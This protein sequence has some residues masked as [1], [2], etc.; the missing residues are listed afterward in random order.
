[1]ILNAEPLKLRDGFQHPEI[2]LHS[3]CLPSTQIY[4]L[5]CTV[6]RRIITSTFKTHNLC[7]MVQVKEPILQFSTRSDKF[8]LLFKERNEKLDAYGSIA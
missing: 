2:A 7:L 6:S 3:V 4:G 8:F 5:S 1:M